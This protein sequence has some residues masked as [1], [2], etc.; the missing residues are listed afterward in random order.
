[1][2][3]LYVFIGG[4]LVLI[5]AVAWIFWSIDDARESTYALCNATRIGEPVTHVADRAQE[6]GLALEKISGSK[7]PEEHAAV[8]EAMRRRFGCTV[9]VKDG[10]V[11]DKR[12]GELPAE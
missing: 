3:F 7:Q 11:I 5:G 2:R 4:L 6:R 1:M 10:R 8:A 9:V 12:F